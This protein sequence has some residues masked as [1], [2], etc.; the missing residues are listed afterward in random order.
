MDEA[1]PIADAIT[2]CVVE[3]MN[4]LTEEVV[5]T[6]FYWSVVENVWIALIIIF[7]LCIIFRLGVL[8]VGYIKTGKIGDFEDDSF[9][10]NL[11]EGHLKDVLP[12]LVSGPFPGAILVDVLGFSIIT[13]VA[14]LIWPVL[15]ILL[16][17]LG[18]AYLI[19]LPIA[20]K[21]EF[22]GRLDGTHKNINTGSGEDCG[23]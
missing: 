2:A 7:T 22:I 1:G 15:A 9:V 17:L 18:L 13:L 21:Q 11:G 4:T 20:R 14:G 19:R 16:P 6:T 10:Y 8:F 23:P 3:T 12:A 5:E